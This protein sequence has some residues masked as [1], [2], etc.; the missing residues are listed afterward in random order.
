MTSFQASTPLRMNRLIKRTITVPVGRKCNQFSDFRA[1]LGLSVIG[2]D[3][4]G[5]LPA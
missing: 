4:S 1:V 2:N 5:D 3:G